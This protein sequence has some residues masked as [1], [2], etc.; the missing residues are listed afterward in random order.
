MPFS[1]LA[2]GG[3]FAKKIL[4]GKKGADDI[5]TYSSTASQCTIL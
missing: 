5:N 1:Q 3:I 4:R 2:R